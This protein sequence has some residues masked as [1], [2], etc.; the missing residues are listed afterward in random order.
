MEACLTTQ[1]KKHTFKQETLSPTKLTKIVLN[2]I[3]GTGR[4]ALRRT[5]MIACLLLV[6]SQ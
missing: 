4:H 1:S 2:E 5:L 3:F 6:F